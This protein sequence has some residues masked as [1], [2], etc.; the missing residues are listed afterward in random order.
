MPRL[1]SLTDQG[2]FHIRA[3]PT[4]GPGGLLVQ[5]SS[6]RVTQWSR[7]TEMPP[8]CSFTPGTRGL[9][10]QCV[11][12]GW[13]RIWDQQT[14][15]SV[16]KWTGSRLFTMHWPGLV[17]RPLLTARGAEMWNPHTCLEGEENQ[18][19]VSIRLLCY[20]ILIF[21]LVPFIVFIFT[22]NMWYMLPGFVPIS[23]FLFVII[24]KEL[25]I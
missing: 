17:M 20:N 3:I 1:H 10:S 12:Q 9:C 11:R 7:Q 13:G 24:P 18:I 8:S 25:T 22:K 23:H 19:G 14:Y 5:V 16:Q 2:W 6:Y 4:A 21:V 15:A